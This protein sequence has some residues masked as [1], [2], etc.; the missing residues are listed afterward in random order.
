MLMVIVNW[1]NI[2]VIVGVGLFVVVIVLSLDVV[3]DL[4]MMG[5]YVCI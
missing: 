3:V 1:F 2:K 5:G 4:L